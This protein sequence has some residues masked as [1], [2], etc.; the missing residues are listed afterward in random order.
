MHLPLSPR[1]T[2]ALICALCYSC[3]ATVAQAGAQ[4]V[5]GQAGTEAGRF[6]S[7]TGIAVDQESGAVYI[8]DRGNQRVDKF[9][10]D[11]EFLL[12]WGWGVAD[13][14]T[15]ALQTCTTTC[16]AGIA[17]SGAGQLANNTIGV[18]V[19]NDPLSAS[20]HDVYVEDA[21]N[22]R[23]DKFTAS[24]E[25]LLT[26]GGGVNITAHEK[27]ETANEDVCPVNPGDVCG[28][29]TSGSEPGQFEGLSANSVAVA[30]SGAVYVADDGRVQ[31]FSEDGRVEAAVS[32][33]EEGE[34]LGLAVDSSEH[35]D[36]LGGSQTGIHRYD[37][38]G[39]E[40]PA[41][42]SPLPT[43]AAAEF[44]F[45]TVFTAAASGTVFVDVPETHRL[46]EYGDGGEELS[47]FGAEE[48]QGIALREGA[49]ELYLERSTG[50]EIV[51][52]PPPGPIVEAPSVQAE[53]AGT[54][55]VTATIDPEGKQTSYHV[56]YGLN[57]PGEASTP[58]ATLAAE[59][60]EPE[61]VKVKLKG[62]QPDSAYHYRLVV[63]N[64]AGAPTPLQGIFTTLA[65]VAVESESVSQVSAE[66]AR[67]SAEID[68]LGEETEY[69]FQYGP[70][71][72]YGSSV[73]VPVGR[74]GAAVVGEPVNVLLEG[75][76]AGTTYHYRVVA[77]NH[78]GEAQGEDRTFTTQ[79]GEGTQLLDGRGWELVSPPDKHGA[80]LEAITKEGGIIQ[81]AEDGAGLAYIAKAPIDNEPAGSRSFAEQQLLAT[82][83]GS[84]WST[85]DIATAHEA[86]AGLRA[87]ELSEYKLFSGD[88]SAGIV[89]PTGATPLSPAA[90]E[91]TPYLREDGDGIYVPLV[92]GCPAVE[93]ECLPSVSGLA[94]VPPGTKFGL[95]EE[96]G[97]TSPNT[98]V[99]FVAATPDL[100][101]AIVTAPQSLVS[102]FETDAQS[103]LYEWS[104]ANP[105]ASRLAPVSI[106]EHG[107]S[108]G[109]LGGA[110]LGDNGKLVR[111]AIS[112]DGQRVV[113]SSGEHLFLRDLAA[114]RTI[115]LDQTE[116]GAAGG[117]GKAAYQGAGN[118]EEKVFFTDESRL[119]KEATS[120]SA[121]PDLYMCE[122]VEAAGEPT[123]SLKDLTKTVNPGE[124]ADVLGAMIG[125][126]ESGSSVYLVATGVL[127]EAS[128]LAGE[129]PQR[130]QPNLYRIDTT[131]GAVSLV[132][133]LS[134]GDSPDWDAGGNAHVALNEVTARV[135]PSGQYLA[136]MS[137]RRLTGYDNR[138]VDGGEPDEEVFEYDSVS[139]HTVCVSCDPSGAR[140]R[141]VRDPGAEEASLLVDRSHTWGEK[142]VAALIP[143]WTPVDIEHALYQSRYLSDEGRLFFDSSAS[144]VPADGNETQDVYEFEPQGT[145][146]CSA[147]AVS[148]DVAFVGE[149]DGNL[150]DGCVG[151]ISSG[152]SGEESA[153][154]DASASG[155]DVFFLTAAKL[156]PSDVDDALDVY[157]A[158]V[159]GVGWACPTSAATAASPCSNAESCRQP[160]APASASG[161]PLSATF[162]GPGDAA[163]LAPTV[164]VKLLTR[165]Q[166]LA[167]ALKACRGK[168]NRRQRLQCE[169][170]AHKRYGPVRKAKKSQHAKQAT[171]R[172]G[173]TR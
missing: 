31:R 118:G 162:S 105:P 51:P 75:L 146:G 138:D 66:S 135:S 64:E 154:L 88:L 36:V 50:V 93:A 40:L 147:K 55:T 68:P 96:E 81:A 98:G 140:P 104:R 119:T 141:G 173:K 52:L 99:E 111:N 89:E 136:F 144:L 145:G 143:G 10:P 13:G 33:S 47:S 148:A 78:L 15:T 107:P 21:G 127:T 56:E 58:T 87:G 130:E 134:E 32:L 103:A 120:V 168:R 84:G 37:D 132:A 139:G 97:K 102:G 169:A 152:T 44:N 115:Q 156:S 46:L 80:A 25:F 123:C 19:N 117:P 62:L 94:D 112:A 110:S 77:V 125:S 38:T 131:T 18:A 161:P 4:T 67:L 71:T 163:P 72:A 91:A 108:A 59:G 150:V 85:Q 149:L 113:F 35:L 76:S 41:P 133:V 42:A 17:G 2:L 1:V 69:R 73:P 100:A 43:N 3:I 86:V 34:I 8:A 54:A 171:E 101:H 155:D 65:A 92:S 7:P 61:V 26:F 159:C 166:K 23:I 6:L 30:P 129:L 39:V 82:H 167:K 124:G 164:A 28:A 160:F 16:F 109:E 24:G 60:F 27:G 5:F 157:D 12:A 20:H 29:G 83:A 153:F 172:G 49:Q 48:A 45:S 170:L 137:Q 57:E 79:A 11:G 95:S 128:D 106:I 121:R 122:V 126:G 22:E 142:W 116:A 151:L 74:L 14:S 90:S 165:A 70:T 9:G 53:P 158:H 114:G 63:E